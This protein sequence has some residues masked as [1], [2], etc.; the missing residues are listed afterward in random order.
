MPM[1][2]E[3]LSVSVGSN[4]QTKAEEKKAVQ[5]RLFCSKCTEIMYEGQYLSYI[6]HA[7]LS[8]TDNS[9]II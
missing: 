4:K 6:L 8:D 3:L 2:S 1:R 5:E 9:P 7:A